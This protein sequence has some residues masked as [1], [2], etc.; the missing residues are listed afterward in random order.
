VGWDVENYG[1]D[2]DIEVDISPQDYVN[3]IDPQLERAIAEALRL[4]EE[5]PGLMPEPG[6]MEKGRRQQEK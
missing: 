6:P 4:I 3:N 1:T 2:P 5:Q